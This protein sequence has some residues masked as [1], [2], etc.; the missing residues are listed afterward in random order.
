MTAAA[1]DPAE[2]EVQGGPGVTEVVAT[3]AGVVFDARH[4][5]HGSYTVGDGPRVSFPLLSLALPD[6]RCFPLMRRHGGATWLS[7]TVDMRGGF[8]EA[9][10]RS[11]LDVL[12]ASGRAVPVDG[13]FTLE[14]VP[15]A[16]AEIRI[17]AVTFSLR[18]VPAARA[19]DRSSGL[20][21]GWWRHVGGMLVG[22]AINAHTGS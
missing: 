6:P 7:F 20:N 13:A 11:S 4:C 22:A 18:D 21:V 10:G 16:R 3:Y 14:L 1:I 2:F 9:T 17:E 15:G 19:R 12:I 5:A 8:V